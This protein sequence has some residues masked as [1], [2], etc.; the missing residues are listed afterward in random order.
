MIAVVDAGYKSIGTHMAF[1]FDQLSSEIDGG[2]GFARKEDW[3]NSF[4]K[5]KYTFPSGEP[6]S[7]VSETS[8]GS[9]VADAGCDETF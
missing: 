6:G 1:S 8:C 9:L 4:S 7:G 2:I 5:E 3:D